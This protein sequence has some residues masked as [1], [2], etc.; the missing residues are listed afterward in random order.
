MRKQ[1]RRLRSFL[2]ISDQLEDNNVDLDENRAEGS[3]EWLVQKPNFRHW[4]DSSS[5]QI[6]WLNGN[7]AT[8]KSF[9]ANYVVG[10]LEDLNY[11]CSYYFFKE[12][13][14]TKSSLSKCFLSLA[15]QMAFSNAAIRETFLE[16]QDDDVRI[17]EENHQSIWRKL[18]IGGILQLKL[19]KTHYWVLDAIDECKKS[20]DLL[21][22]ISK[23]SSS[24]PL[25]IFL[26]SRPNL[27]LQCQLQPLD[28]PVEIQQVL[29]EHTLN[30]IM[31]YVEQHTDFP[32]MQELRTRQHLVAAILDKSEGCFLW[33]R[34]VLKELRKVHSETATRR[35]LEDVPQ[36]MDKLYVRTLANMSKE[37]YGKPLAKAILM[38]VVCSVRPLLTTELRHAI[39]I[40]IGDNVY[41]L[42][43]QIA[44]LC[45]NLVYVDSHLRIKMIHQTARNHLLSLDNDSEFA[46]REKDGHRQ[47]GLTCL[48]YLM[49]DEMKAP[50]LRR[51]SVAQSVTQRSSFLDYAANSFYEHVDQASSTD[52]ELLN[53]LYSFL[54]TSNGNVQSWI[55]Y[56]A[57]GGDLNHLTQT[58]MILRTYLRRRAKHLLSLGKE[59]ETIDSW[60]TDLIRIVPKFGR[61]LLRFPPSIY[62]IIPSFCPR[63]SILYQQFNK[64]AR[65]ILVMGLTSTTWNDHLACIF[66]GNNTTTAVACSGSH[67]AIGASNKI[68]RLYQTSTCQEFRNLE[69]GEPV[70]SLE[71][72]NSGQLLVSA[73]RKLVLVWDVASRELVQQF[74][75]SRPCITMTLTSDNKTLILAC[76]D[77]QLNFYDLVN[78]TCSA[79]EQWYV[80]NSHSK[81]IYRTPVTAAF[82]LDHKLLAV[83]YRGSHICLW[84]WDY[85]SFSGF[86]KKP[87]VTKEALPFHASSLVFSPAPNT[88]SLAAAYEGGE[89]I[90]FNPVEGDIK[91]TYKSYADA[92]TLACSQDGRTLIS[93]DSSGTIRIFDF[94]FFDSQN[95]KLLY[96]IHGRGD[97]IIALAFCGDNLRFVDIRGPQSNVWEPAVLVRQDVGEGT[98]DV[99]SIGLQETPMPTS[100][101]VISAIALEPEGNFI[102]CGTEEGLINIYKTETGRV[103]QTL[104]RHSSGVSITILVFDG[105]K[106]IVASA[107]SSS[108]ILVHQ[109]CLES[110]TWKTKS[111]LLEHRM[112]E[113]IEQL[114]FNPESTK[115]LIATTTSDIL[116]ALDSGAKK[117]ILWTTRN[118][119]IWTNHPQQPTQLLLILS[120]TIRIY[121]WEGLKELT[122]GSGI[123]LEFEIPM[124]FEIRTSYSGWH[125]RIIVTEYSERSRN[126]SRSPIRLL[127]WSTANLVFSK[128]SVSPHMSLQPIGNRLTYLIGTFGTIIAMTTNTL[129]FLD[130]EGWICSVDIDDTTPEYYKRH[131]FLP[132]DWLSTND[133]LIF[134]F[135]V[136][137]DIVFC[138]IDEI[139]I[140]KRGLDDMEMILFESKEQ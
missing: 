90:V 136:K 132:D 65:G 105:N 66:Y 2:C 102:F 6:F 127:F 80:D 76:L 11:D 71:F 138:K 23:T 37:S 130:R 114:L 61:N 104:Y 128:T 34:L 94:E 57:R 42:E 135:T 124:N 29:P 81:S 59:L 1:K 18:F 54:S 95:L 39:Q 62:H 19:Y 110:S 26:T 125:G 101:D 36:G 44:C 64:S 50:R 78:G 10:H 58:G 33:V 111:V 103:S 13:D 24:F 40:N 118:A 109:L 117:S 70:K 55:E 133:K 108:K 43:N 99:I 17:D 91:A 7:P 126:R 9:L 86:C 119:G 22:L 41:N 32:S 82:S 129:L 60:S 140:I 120:K 47:L 31:L 79:R 84:N 63:E 69:H 3:C 45:G 98:S 38:W 12:G 15:Y 8:G 93:G 113:S 35:I 115:I 27:E 116:C 112:E 137:Q 68:I 49:S 74:R 4:R 28:P 67:F 14:K 97:N 89:L 16:M 21:P 121:D 20:I 92:Q 122:A 72:N 75:T 53:H 5:T 123:G 56:V 30:D 96:V 52:T 88:D 48:K 139:A 107:D 25:R 46:F 87:S 100:V 83:V 77:N 131:F 51:P 85:G 73:G 106:Q 134:G